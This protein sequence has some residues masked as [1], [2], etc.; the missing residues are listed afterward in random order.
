MLKQNMTEWLVEQ[1]KSG[2]SRLYA[3][4]REKTR[5]TSSVL[6][7]TDVLQGIGQRLVEH[8]PAMKP[9]VAEAEGGVLQ[10]NDRDVKSVGVPCRLEDATGAC[11]ESGRRG[12]CGV[13][14]EK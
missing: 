5:I 1:L 3:A 2:T 7:R 14:E 11:A 12:D 9:R 13:R 6:N 10:W 8:Q 4:Y